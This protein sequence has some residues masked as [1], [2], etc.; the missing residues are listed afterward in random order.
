MPIPKFTH[1][2]QRLRG[3]LADRLLHHVISI[4]IDPL[5]IAAQYG[6]MM[7]DPVGNSKYCFTLLAAY[8]ADV[9]EARVLSGVRGNA[10]H[11]TTATKKQF[12]DSFRHPTRTALATLSELNAIIATISPSDLLPF[13]KACHPSLNGVDRPFWGD[14]AL[15]EPAIS[16]GPEPLHHWWKFSHDH[17]LQWAVN[18]VG[19][20]ELDYRFTLLQPLIGYR[21]FPEG[22]TVL[23]SPTGRD[24]Q[25]I[26]RYLIGVIAGAVPRHCLIALRAL[27]D[28][29]H[30]AQA[31]S[32][33]DGDIAN[34]DR[35]LKEFHDYKSSII[36]AGA[37]G[38]KYVIQHWD[39]PKLELF[40]SVTTS[41]RLQGSP[42]QWTAEV[43]E[44][45]HIHLVKK[46]AR[47]G[48]NHDSHS[49]MCRY[50]DR[51][52]KCF[53]FDHATSILQAEYDGDDDENDSDPDQHRIGR[54]IPDYF[55]RA[56]GLLNGSYPTAPR[57]YRTF[58][59]KRTAFHISR[60]P[61]LTNLT[62]DTAIETF[63][64][65]DLRN[66]IH[67]FLHCK[68]TGSEPT[69]RDAR[70]TPSDINPLP[71]SRIQVWFKIRV[72]SMPHYVE[73]SL[74][75][76]QA[77]SAQPPHDAWPLGRYDPAIVSTS[78]E[79]LW[80]YHGLQGSSLLLVAV[81][82]SYRSPGHLVV[83][84]RMMFRPIWPDRPA[85]VPDEILAYVQPFTTIRH[86]S[87]TGM[88]LLTRAKYSNGTRRGYIIP[89]TRICSHAHLIPHFGDK[90]CT[91]LRMQTVLEACEH[92]WLNK[93]GDGSFFFA[94]SK[95]R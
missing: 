89:V 70:S 65:F 11:V 51:V 10:S 48:N 8:I 52:E 93:Y 41:I 17:D 18:L 81:C 61:S 59:A 2:N 60:D 47:S 33:R 4:V 87:S 26:H 1:P 66:A 63:Q 68:L 28:F 19:A 56:K 21:R 79:S 15:A 76:P 86:D 45:A 22:V 46:P 95:S 37:R 16:F 94:L 71:F 7:S 32:F 9:P 58:A 55:A 34:L 25:N 39:I 36:K 85:A 69:S 53:L 6:R 40:Q 73:D 82:N 12:G 83:Q 23:K 38:G 80:P 42:M 84:L 67:H 5:K 91:H 77:L 62:L 78:D 43:T 49:Q 88:D 54:K 74:E 75:P 35:A 13:F 72:Q 3:M 31:P 90:A 30:Y 92:F 29:R 57:P 20:D 24:H 14:W 64:L 27:N 44:R 50:L